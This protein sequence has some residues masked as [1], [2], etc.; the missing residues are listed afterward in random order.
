MPNDPYCPACQ[1]GK[2]TKVH[3]RRRAPDGDNLPFGRK[4][5]ADTLYARGDKSRALD[6]SEYAIV[7]VDIGT[8]WLSCVPTCERS[9]ADAREAMRDIVG[10][11]SRIESFYSDGAKEL[12]KAAKKLD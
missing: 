6:G 4:C 12:I 1:I 7:F 11:D 9:A 10:P 8:N 5:I 3:A 2:L